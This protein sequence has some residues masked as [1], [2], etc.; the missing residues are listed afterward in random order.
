MRFKLDL[1]HD[2]AVLSFL[3]EGDRAMT[4]R[5]VRVEHAL[6]ELIGE[7]IV[8]F[9]DHGALHCITFMHASKQL[10]LGAGGS[11]PPMR[12]SREPAREAAYLYLT[13]EA[14]PGVGQTVEV[15]VPEGEPELFVDFD[16]A[17]RVIGI[18]F[19][20]PSRQL[21]PEILPNGSPTHQESRI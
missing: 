21:R 18:E 4:A 17:G 14:R 12:F 13:D 19:L 15:S 11:Q 7:L 1:E 20:G 8:R 9:A 5:T 10:R 6:G 2:I 3:A 16:A